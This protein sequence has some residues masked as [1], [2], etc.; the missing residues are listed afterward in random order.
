[1]GTGVL[2]RVVIGTGETGVEKE[3]LARYRFALPYCEGKYVADI[4]CG[5]GYGSIMLSQTAN[6]V[7]GYDKENLCG[8]VVMDF[9]LE[10]WTE[11]YGLI[12]SFE[13][14]EHLK[15]P[16]NFLKNIR[17]TAKESLISIPLNEPEGVNQY[18]LHTFTEESA[19]ALIQSVFS[20]CE[21]FYQEGEV[22][23][24]TAYPSFLIAY[25]RCK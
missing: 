24:K 23:S 3:H 20:K 15:D 21:F 9:D 18:H 22:I 5:T 2:E 13:T 17:D 1:M 6:L 7:I 16:K 8:N 19:K 12:V 4:A 11:K 14:V 10:R 25:V